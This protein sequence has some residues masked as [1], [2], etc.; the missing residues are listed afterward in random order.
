ME[1]F[2][3]TDLL[4]VGEILQNGLKSGYDGNIWVY[5]QISLTPSIA[6]MLSN[7]GVKDSNL[8]PN[9]LQIESAMWQTYMNIDCGIIKIDTRGIVDYTGCNGRHIFGIKQDWIAPQWLQFVGGY[10]RQTQKIEPIDI[11]PFER[12]YNAIMSAKNNIKINIK[13]S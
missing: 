5:N 4:A 7:K 2:H 9:N 3:G 10:N 13:T 12:I 11:A 8:L 1:L 6:M